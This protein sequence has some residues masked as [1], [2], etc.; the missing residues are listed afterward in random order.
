MTQSLTLSAASVPPKTYLD[1]C[2]AQLQPSVI[3]KIESDSYWKE[4]A[5]ATALVA[6]TTLSAGFF[7]AVATYASV[8]LSIR[9]CFAIAL[10]LLT[11][12]IAVAERLEKKWI[13]PAKAD[14]EHA[15]DLKETNRYY[16]VLTELPLE[17]LLAILLKA[18]IDWASIPCLSE[19]PENIHTLK[20]LIAHHVFWA[21]RTKDLEKQKKYALRKAEKLATPNHNESLKEINKL[22]NQAQGLERSALESKVNDAFVLA[23]IQRPDLTGSLSDIGSF[24][25]FTRKDRLIDYAI[26]NSF[27]IFK[28]TAFAPLTVDQITQTSA[29]NLSKRLLAAI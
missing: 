2:N 25:T 21:M 3:K 14:A 15:N 19:K 29:A 9:G 6:F 5:D 26:V 20:P 28:N 7:I 8:S 16:Q 13:Q 22:Y 23:A 4:V 11:I 24:P 27:F 17:A 1:Y 12:T 18:G 10:V